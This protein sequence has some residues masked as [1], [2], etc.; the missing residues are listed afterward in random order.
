MI[1]SFKSL[2][3]FTKRL[4]VEVQNGPQLVSLVNELKYNHYL[5]IIQLIQFTI[6]IQFVIKTLSNL[7]LNAIIF[8]VKH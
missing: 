1:N 4:I 7:S 8:Q 6:I 5:V 3:I 2:S